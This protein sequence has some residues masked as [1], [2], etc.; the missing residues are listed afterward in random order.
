[1]KAAFPLAL[2]G[3]ADLAHPIP[4]TF[5]IRNY[6]WKSH[7]SGSAPELRPNFPMTGQELI[8]SSSSRMPE[9][10]I[11]TTVLLTGG[12]EPWSSDDSCFPVHPSRWKV[13]Q[14]QG[15]PSKFLTR[16]NPSCQLLPCPAIRRN[17]HSTGDSLRFTTT[18]K[19]LV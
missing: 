14:L 1:M 11:N 10:L 6:H 7:T 12:E 18:T 3:S 9:M 2:I 17:Y 19:Y 4:P 8:E 5:H 15:S 13:I 16:V